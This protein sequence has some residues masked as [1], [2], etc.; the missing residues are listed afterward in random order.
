MRANVITPNTDKKFNEA[1]AGI[2]AHRGTVISAQNKFLERKPTTAGRLLYVF[3][4]ADLRLGHDGLAAEASKHKTKEYPQGIDVSQFLPGQLVVFVNHK[5]DKFKVFAAHGV[6]AYKRLEKGCVFDMRVIQYIPQA[7]N[8]T[9]KIDYDKLLSNVIDDA[10]KTL[11]PRKF[12]ASVRAET[13]E[14]AAE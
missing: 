10:F 12:A 13:T 11:H 7:F 5:M 1:V 4:N 9:G 8:A 14:E 6:V 2:V 3:T